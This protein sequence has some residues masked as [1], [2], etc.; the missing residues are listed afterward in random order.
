MSTQTISTGSK[1]AVY[2]L[3]SDGQLWLDN[4][5]SDQ[6]PL[7]GRVHIYTGAL[8]CGAANETTVYV[9]GSDGNYSETR[10]G[11]PFTMTPARWT[12]NHWLSGPH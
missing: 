2:V 8:G 1:A 4:G 5:P 12:R 11:G 3:G 9:L 10:S 6:V 7:P